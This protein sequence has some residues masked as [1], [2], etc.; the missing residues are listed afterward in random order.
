MQ[1]RPPPSVPQERTSVPTVV[2]FLSLTLFSTLHHLSSVFEPD[3]HYVIPFFNT[4]CSSGS[5]EMILHVISQYCTHH[6]KIVQL[7]S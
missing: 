5:K 1:H 6:L 4:L 7:S 3:G 2:R